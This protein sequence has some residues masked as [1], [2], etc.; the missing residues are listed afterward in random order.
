M[1][2]FIDNCTEISFSAGEA[3]SRNLLQML[4]QLDKEYMD[5]LFNGDDSLVLIRGNQRITLVPLK[6]NERNGPNEY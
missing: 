5:R 3:S 1:S 2:S 6:S 4:E